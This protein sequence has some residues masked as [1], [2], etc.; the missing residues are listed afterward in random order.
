MV[1]NGFRAKKKPSNVNTQTITT[2]TCI[3][4]NRPLLGAKFKLK[5]HQM[6]TNTDQAKFNAAMK[7][8][9]IEL[10]TYGFF[11]NV[12]GVKN[13][14][15]IDFSTL[16]SFDLTASNSVFISRKS[17]GKILDYKCL[18]VYKDICTVD[19]N[20]QLLEGRVLDAKAMID[21]H[22]GAKNGA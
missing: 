11:A 22:M 12:N 21:K 14:V 6:T 20:L 15:K 9:V 18:N 4:N 2:T 10:I 5:G 13:C 1:R 17:D 8:A 3:S 7:D 19:E 16:S